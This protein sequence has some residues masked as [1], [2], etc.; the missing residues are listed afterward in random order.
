MWRPGLELRGPACLLALAVFFRSALEV[1]QCCRLFLEGG[2]CSFPGTVT[3]AVLQ[4]L[5]TVHW[6]ATL[7]HKALCHSRPEESVNRPWLEG[8]ILSLPGFDVFREFLVGW[9]RRPN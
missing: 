7:T 6:T 8:L 5:C 1:S 2:A 3:G 4:A 9:T